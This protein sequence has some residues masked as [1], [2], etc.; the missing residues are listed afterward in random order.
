MWNQRVASTVEPVTWLEF[1]AATALERD[2]LRRALPAV[3]SSGQSHVRATLEPGLP[4]R[5]AIG[6]TGT[7]GATP[8]GCVEHL[9][10]R[11]LLV[12]AAWKVLDLLL[13][14]SLDQAAVPQ[15]QRRGYSIDFKQQQAQAATARPTQLTALLWAPLMATYD[16]SVEIRHS[17]VHR[18]VHT[19]ATGALVGR[20]RVG[21]P[22][23]PM[24]PKEQEA[25]ARAVLGAA[26]QALASATD[27]R[28]ESRLARHLADLA[29]FHGHWVTAAAM[30]GV[31]PELTVV[32]NPDP[33]SPQRYLLDMA[34]VR[35][36][37]PFRAGGDHADLIIAPRDRPG[38]EL[39]GR[40][41]E[42]PNSV[43]SIDPDSPP[44][45]LH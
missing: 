7:I 44:S 36:R 9:A 45:W 1:D 13:E 19:D 6:I 8:E 41:E 38:Q 28:S 26:E 24:P 18:R 4:V 42:A 33:A 10:L 15:D 25:F 11:P 40:L 12:G 22:L 31:M 43:V 16:A 23:R 30:P 21:Q 34:D 14:E 3:P 37:N 35:A 17:L 27:A 2:V 5:A 39:Y 20:D 32:V 29:G